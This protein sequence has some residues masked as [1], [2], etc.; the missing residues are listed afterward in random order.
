MLSFTKNVIFRSPISS[1][2][3]IHPSRLP[4][5]PAGSFRTRTQDAHRDPKYRRAL[6]TLPV[7]QRSVE[8]RMHISDL[9]AY[10]P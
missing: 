9:A 5:M 6:S 2:L 4:G 8:R 3:M 1:W 7:Y 10:F